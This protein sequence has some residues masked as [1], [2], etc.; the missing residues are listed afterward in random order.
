MCPEVIDAT[1][2]LQIWRCG[3]KKVVPKH[4]GNH[5]VEPS[6]VLGPLWSEIWDIYFST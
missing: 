2:G 6:D 5:R 1:S 4:V 3:D